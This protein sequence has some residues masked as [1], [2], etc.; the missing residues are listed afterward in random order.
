MSQNPQSTD[1]MVFQIGAAITFPDSFEI[2]YPMAPLVSVKI[3]ENGKNLHIR[4]VVFID[5]ANV[6]TPVL[7]DPTV[8]GTTLQYTVQ[9]RC[10]T[11]MPKAY[12]T[13]FAGIQYPAEGINTV[14]IFLEN[15]DPKTSRGTVTTVL[16]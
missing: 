4:A 16:K 3:G 15:E 8:N 6:N 10:V 1:S 13:W 2:E 11:D 12:V 5:A 7:S 14:E 9:Y